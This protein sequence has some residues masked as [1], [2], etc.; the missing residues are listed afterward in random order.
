MIEVKV[1][2]SC[3]QPYVFDV[4]PVKGRMPVPVQCPNCGV[5]GTEKANRA[6]QEKFASMAEESSMFFE[7][8]PRAVSKKPAIRA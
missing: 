2:C 8:A 6:I 3:G 4:E 5:D 7:G 1:Q